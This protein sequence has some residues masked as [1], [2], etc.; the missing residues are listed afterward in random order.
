MFTREEHP[1]RNAEHALEIMK[2]KNEE[3]ENNFQIYEA[4]RGKSWSVHHTLVKRVS[5]KFA[6][7]VRS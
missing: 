6:F 7:V 4:Y 2:Q 3:R 5:I 1:W